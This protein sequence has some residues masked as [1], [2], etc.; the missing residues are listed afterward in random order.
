VIDYTALT[1]QAHPDEVRGFAQWASAPERD[2][3]PMAP[4]RYRFGDALG[5][6]FGFIMVPIALVVPFVFYASAADVP[7]PFVLV[8][9]F[10]I[11]CGIAA[12]V[13][14][15]RSR[16]AGLD[17]ESM[18]RWNEFAE[19]NGLQYLPA[20]ARAAWADERYPGQLFAPG[21][22]VFNRLRSTSGRPFEI[23]SHRR[24]NGGSSSENWHLHRGYVA[25]KLDRRLPQ[26]VLEAEAN[27]S[28]HTAF[29]VGGSGV[30]VSLEGDFD[31]HFTLRVPAGYESDARYVLTPDLMALL[32]DETSAF[33]VEL[34]DDWMF[35]Y[36]P[37]PFVGAEPALFERLFSILSTVGVKA[38][39]QTRRYT[40]SRP[41][42]SGERG[43]RFVRGTPLW[44]I[45]IS[46]AAIAAFALALL[47]S[48][49]GSDSIR[50]QF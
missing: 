27:A 28:L 25:V 43:A 20:P 18:Y 31:E 16:F 12:L 22:R 26:I 40:D 29:R 11:G 33:D 41:R 13:A 34:V 21:T 42:F 39:S 38:I 37:E 48:L 2:W 15:S 19:D 24:S 10:F 32:I 8:L 35:I 9:L 30:V 1:S 6:V 36:S 49:I 44:V 50:L 23:G 3:E 47:L 14:Q 45:V 7:L 4:V 5:I 46:W 17:W